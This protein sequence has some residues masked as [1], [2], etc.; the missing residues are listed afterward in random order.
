MPRIPEDALVVTIR[1]LLRPIVRRLLSWGVSYPVVDRVVRALFVEVAEEDLALPRKRVT[2]SRVSLVTGIHRKE[3]A[4]L[5]RQPR[6]ERNAA[7]LETSVVTR[8]IGRWLASPPFVDGKGRARPLPYEAQ[9]RGM[10]S[11]TRLVS[12]SGFDGPVRSVL[13]EMLRR[14]AVSWR[15]DGTVR[16]VHEANVPAADLDTKLDLLGSDPAELFQ[17]IAHNVEQPETPWLQRKVVYDNVGADALP[18]LRAAARRE[19]ET[20]IR[21]GNALLAA[22][23]RD[24]NADA[25]GGARTR[26]VL[27]AYW[28]EE[29]VDGPAE[30]SPPETEPGPPGRITARGAVKQRSR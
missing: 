5:R 23:D 30:P 9:P 13:D 18:S 28:F 12:E 16:L 21:R 3:I 17:T 26:V 19:G 4:R 6:T 29:P 24:R 7:P 27:A 2:D 11:F 1:R 14:G 25:A 8:V 20:L 22:H 15:G 10:A